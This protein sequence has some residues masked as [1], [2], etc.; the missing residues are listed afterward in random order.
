MTDIG[1]CIE[2]KTGHVRDVLGLAKNYTKYGLS[3]MR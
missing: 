2:K 3:D 1:G